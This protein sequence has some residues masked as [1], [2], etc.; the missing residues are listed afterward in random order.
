MRIN[1][2]QTFNFR[3]QSLPQASQT[4]KLSPMRDGLNTAGL[5]FGFGVALDLL[6][7]K[8]HFAKSPFKN[9]LALNGVIGAAAGLVV[10]IQDLKNNKT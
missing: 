4:K 2:I 10:W 1:S 7:R 9:S 3:A 5:W 6:S 8:I